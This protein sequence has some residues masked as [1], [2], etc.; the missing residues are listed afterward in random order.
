MLFFSLVYYRQHT[1]Y[2]LYYFSY[3]K[4][5]YE[6]Y[7]QHLSL[8]IS[9]F[10]VFNWLNR[11]YTITRFEIFNILFFVVFFGYYYDIKSATVRR[12]SNIKCLLR[13]LLPFLSPKEK[14]ERICIKYTY[15]IPWN[16]LKI[17][18][19]AQECA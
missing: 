6:F 13:P 17:N 15:I 19:L 8:S 5:M 9:H 1:L 14:R 11:I 12:D 16:T 18:L 10:E 4:N 2:I 3:N 7:F